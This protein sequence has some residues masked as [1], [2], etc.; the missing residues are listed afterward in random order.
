MGLL[1]GTN[2]YTI[3]PLECGSFKEARRWR[4]YVQDKLKPLEIK[5][6]SPLD[7]MFRNFK[8]ESESTNNQ[9]KQALKDGKYEL[10]HEEMKMIRNRD[11]AAC[12][13]STFLIA[14]IEPGIATYGSIDEIVTSKR[15]QKPVFLVI[16]DKGFEA[17]PLWLASY[18]QPNWVY[19]NLDEVIDTIYKI[20]SG[21]IPIKNK[22]WKILDT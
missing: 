16:P 7:K 13:L 2:C 3:G 6:L 5:I 20:D 21:E 22:Y 17:I 9:L 19:K 1:Q 18:F 4:T 12:D 15:N 10:V 14:I 11:L 8:T